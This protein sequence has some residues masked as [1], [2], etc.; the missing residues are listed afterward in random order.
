MPRAMWRLLR[1]RPQVSVLLIAAAKGQPVRRA[2]LADTGAG[3]AAVGFDLLLLEQDCLAAGGMPIVS[4]A[5]GGAYAGLF[6]SYAVRVQ[7]PVLGFDE[8]VTVIG[9][10]RLPVGFDGIATFQFLNRFTYG[11]FGDASQFGLE[12]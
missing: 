2:L 11:N 7:L 1:A 12:R 9:V 6:P 10:N 8:D 5:L 4:V 3:S